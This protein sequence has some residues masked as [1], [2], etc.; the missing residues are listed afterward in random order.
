MVFKTNM[1]ILTNFLNYPNILTDQNL[2][3]LIIAVGTA[4]SYEIKMHI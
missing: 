1:N 2:S 3:Y 4:D